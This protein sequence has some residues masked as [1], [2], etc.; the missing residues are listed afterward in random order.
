MSRLVKFLALLGPLSLVMNCSISRSS[1]LAVSDQSRL[2]FFMVARKAFK[3]LVV[4]DDSACLNV[5]KPA[6][7]SAKE[8]EAVKNFIKC[9]VIRNPSHEVQDFLFRRH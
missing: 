2:N 3:H 6:L 4:G 1:R 8:F 9:G 5:T 7:D